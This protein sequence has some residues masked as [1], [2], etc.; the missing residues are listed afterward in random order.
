MNFNSPMRVRAFTVV[1]LLVVVAIIG[2]LVAMLLP[3]L[4]KAKQ[5]ARIAACAANVR[6]HGQ[7]YSYY[8]NDSRDGLPMPNSPHAVR[9]SINNCVS[10][11]FSSN[12]IGANSCPDNPG[13]VNRNFP[14]GLAVF[15]YMGYVPPIPVSNPGSKI[16]MLDCPDQPSFRGLGPSRAQYY[17]TTQNALSSLT[18]LFAAKTLNTGYAPGGATAWDCQ[19]AGL[20]SYI[21]RGWVR[22]PSLIASAAKIT[23]RTAGWSSDNV[24]E[25]E[26]E[27]LDGYFVAGQPTY[28]DMDVHGE[29]QNLLFH[30]GHVLYGGKNI[31]G[32]RPAVYYSVNNDGQTLLNAQYSSTNALVCNNVG[33]TQNATSNGNLALWKYYEQR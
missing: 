33:G 30:D 27:Y 9:A 23:P 12:S 22:T 28:V 31:N 29:A 4:Q 10:P 3:A 20:T 21:Y 24:L 13:N 32:L 6:T 5:T 14:V 18:K 25:V 19:P 7:L 11:Q 17:E 1:E 26:N 8:A 2:I 15:Y 16:G